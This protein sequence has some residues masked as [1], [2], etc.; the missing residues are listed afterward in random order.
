MNR[1]CDFVRFFGALR[2]LLVVTVLVLIVVAPFAD[3]PA[4]T[5]GWALVRSVIAPTVFV[6]MAFVVPLDITMTLVFMS[7]REGPEQRRLK[8]IAQVEAVLFVA[9]LAAWAP[10]VIGLLRTLD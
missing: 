4:Y 8:R 9:M 10:L 6:I 5:T 7:N 2:L 3:G 1:L